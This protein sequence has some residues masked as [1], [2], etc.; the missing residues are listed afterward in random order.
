[1]ALPS[2]IAAL[3]ETFA[4]HEADYT[5]PDFKEAQV[6]QQFIDPFFAALG[7]DVANT[8]GY[9]EAYKEV[10]HE[11]ALKIGGETKAPDYSFR[12]GDQSQ[13]WCVKLAS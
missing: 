13:V 1:M 7:W 8:T 11:D 5:A 12:I 3:I 9:A 4:A 2:E 6:R 10:I